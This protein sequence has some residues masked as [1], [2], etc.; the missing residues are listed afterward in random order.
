MGQLTVY[1][2]EDQWSAMLARG[3]EVDFFGTRL[4]LPAER[5]FADLASVQRYVD[6]VLALPSIR[7]RYPAAGSVA[8]RERRGQAKAHYEPQTASIALPLGS[9]RAAQ[10]PADSAR[11]ANWAGRESVVL[12]ECAHHLACSLGPVD[13]SARERWHGVDFRAAMCALVLAVLGDEAALV[14]R[15][16]Y[17][18]AGLPVVE[19]GA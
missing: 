4:A 19:A 15:A 13:T 17:E 5:K 10:S 16:G 14:L 8:V 18:A 1:A 12:H 7:E 3:G 2:V 6:A 9:A 11:T